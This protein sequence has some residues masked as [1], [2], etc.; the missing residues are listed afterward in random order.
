MKYVLISKTKTKKKV[1]LKISNEIINSLNISFNSIEKTII[2]TLN[3]L[4]YIDKVYTSEDIINGNFD[5]GYD[6][7]IQ[8]GYNVLRSG[9]IIFKLKSKTQIK[10]A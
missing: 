6:L 10:K 5:S 8:N 9:D 4:E 2:N 7:L 1:F 3:Q